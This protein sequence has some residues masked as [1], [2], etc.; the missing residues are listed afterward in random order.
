MSYATIEDLTKRSKRSLSDSDKQIGETLLEDAGIM[1][2]SYNK[3]ASDDAKKVVSCNMVLR[4]LGDGD[5]A[6]APIG[7]TQITQSALGYS[8]SFTMGNGSVGEL[9]LAKSDKKLL[10]VS[11]KLCFASPWKEETV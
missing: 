9:Y 2:D 6:L 3:K 11:N 7:S 4:A 10:G 8:Q 5:S 1:I